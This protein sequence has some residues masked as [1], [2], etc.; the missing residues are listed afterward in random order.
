M[1]L[2]EVLLIFVGLMSL[3]LYY[4][5]LLGLGWKK[6]PGA[7]SKLHEFASTTLTGISS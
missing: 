5:C 4:A 6:K 1:S 3:I 2:R 7:A